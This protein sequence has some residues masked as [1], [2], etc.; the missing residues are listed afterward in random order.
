M[1]LTYEML[2]GLAPRGR[3]DILQ[4]IVD[5]QDMMHFAEIRPGPRRQ[6]FLA[7]LAHESDGFKTTREY[8]SGRAYEGRTDLGN[9]EEGD[10]VRFRGRGLIQLTGRFN[11]EK[12]NA[13]LPADVDIIDEP[14]LVEE[15]PLALQAA[16]WYWDTRK[17]N[18]LADDDSFERITR[19]INGGLNGQADRLAYL[20]KAQELDL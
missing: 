11:Y 3:E 9:T 20:S 8:A 1:D 13:L 14:E 2:E 19:K 7:Q 16:V 15:F 18:S 4:G 12:L 6:M 10:G 17:L 5:N